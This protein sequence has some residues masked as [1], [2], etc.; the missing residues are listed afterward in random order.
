VDT[1]GHVSIFFTRLGL[2]MELN[3]DPGLQHRAV[4]TMIGDAP[5]GWWGEQGRL[6]FN[7]LVRYTSRYAI[8]KVPYNLYLEMSVRQRVGAHLCGC[9]PRVYALGNSGR[10][11]KR[12][13]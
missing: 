9:L 1:A 12:N 7:P 2:L 13:G 3:A 4:L 10:V 5:H 6:V 11:N 8:A